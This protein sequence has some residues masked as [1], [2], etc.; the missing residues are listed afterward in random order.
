MKK[1]ELLAIAK[2]ISEKKA[3]PEETLAYI[4]AVKEELQALTNMIKDQNAKK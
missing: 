2:K 3:T 4:K 1:E